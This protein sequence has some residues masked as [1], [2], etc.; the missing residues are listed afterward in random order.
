MKITTMY[1][2]INLH[3]KFTSIYIKNMIRLPIIKVVQKLSILI[4]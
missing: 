4:N 3:M 1:F 2:I